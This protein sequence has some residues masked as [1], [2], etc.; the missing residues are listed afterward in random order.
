MRASLA[1]A[2]HVRL[3]PAY[4][5]L[6]AWSCFSAVGLG[7][8]VL[9]AFKT[10][11]ELIVAPWGLPG[12]A[13][14]DN[15]AYAWGLGKLSVFFVNSAL[16]VAL[17]VAAVLVVSAP[18]AYVLTKARFR[19]RGALTNY[20]VLGMGIPIPLLYIPLFALLT[21][22]GLSDGLFGLG[23]VFVATSIPFTV[24]LLTGFFSGIPSAIADAGV[25]DGCTEWQLFARIQLPLARSGLITAAI[26]NTI[27]LW[28]EY[29]LSMVLI[30]S[31]GSKT[32]PLGLF[33]LQNATQYSGNWTRLYAAVTIVVVPTLVAFV[34]FSERIISGVTAGAVK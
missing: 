34:F 15:F 16:V 18:A 24:Y 13:R 9:G 27:W 19:F 29:Q 12:A 23:L 31:E 2:R 26:F 6:G 11:R 10:Q 30:S 14:A 4:A 21:R 32:V 25:M 1:A 3:L 7:Y 5:L 28:N 17:S 33:A 8:V 20:L 22:V